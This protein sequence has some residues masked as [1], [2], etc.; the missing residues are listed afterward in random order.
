MNN[1]D[2][3]IDT[4][5]SFTSLSDRAFVEIHVGPSKVPV[6]LKI[7]TGSAAVLLP[8]GHFKQINLKC[9]LEASEKRLTSYT[10]NTLPIKGKFA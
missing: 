4:V 6:K 1:S 10:G 9:P 5:N 8:M 2:Y 7:D 3:H